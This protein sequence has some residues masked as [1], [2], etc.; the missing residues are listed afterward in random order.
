MKKI[1]AMFA[2]HTNVTPKAVG[3]YTIAEI[4]Y[5]IEGINENNKESQEQSS[6]G[7]KVSGLDAIKALQKGKI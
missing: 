3:D 4:E 7:Q 1:Y 6:G 2:E 5:L